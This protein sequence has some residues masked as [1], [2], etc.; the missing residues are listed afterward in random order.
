MSADP[1]VQGADEDSAAVLLHVSAVPEVTS[2]IGYFV[3]RFALLEALLRKCVA[4]YF[5]Y[6][7]HA[8]DTE[9]EDFVL[10]RLN[11]NATTEVVAKIIEVMGLDEF[12]SL[13]ALAG[14]ARARRNRLS[15][16]VMSVVYPQ[17][18]T[19]DPV[20]L[21]PTNVT[22]DAVSSDEDLSLR[23]VGVGVA[24]PRIVGKEVDVLRTVVARQQV[25]GRVRDELFTVAE[26]A[27]W[28]EGLD[29]AVE[30]AGQLVLRLATDRVHNEGYLDRPR[31][32]RTEDGRLQAVGADG[33]PHGGGATAAGLVP[34]DDRDTE[35]GEFDDPDIPEPYGLPRGPRVWGS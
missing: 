20:K 14:E 16:A 13:P 35:Y 32:A 7:V 10:S 18:D 30:A 6:G 31:M 5:G 1:A 27:G 24:D 9:F 11:A 28:V 26:L 12:R 29:K 22:V 33:R 8:A 21:T 4:H 2:G 25:H 23:V 17:G 19:T 15:H 34:A 3:A